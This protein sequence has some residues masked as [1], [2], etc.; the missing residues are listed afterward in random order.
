MKAL[1][2]RNKQRCCC[3]A[4]RPLRRD[5]RALLEDQLRLKGYN[6]SITF[7]SPRCMADLNW[8][9]LRHDGPT[10]IL[11]FDYTSDGFLHGE[12]VICPHVAEQNA[13]RYRVSLEKELRRYI[14]HGVL[15]LLGHDD[16]D[17]RARRK[18]KREENRLL[19]RLPD[20]G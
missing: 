9:H 12:L 11:T 19:K 17:P 2:F 14:I 4:T 20:Y 6:L 18:M 1:A 13:R 15:H 7:V 10:D 3:F 16:K 5:T 8:E